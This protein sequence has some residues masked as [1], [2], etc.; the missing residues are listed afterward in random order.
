MK[1]VVLSLCAAVLL[2]CSK[3]TSASDQNWPQWR[4]PEGQGHAIAKDFPV[5]WSETE[6]IAWKTE[7]PGRGWSSPV[8]WGG[9]MWLTT[10]I[11][12]PAK[13]EDIER[14]T[15]DNTG[16]QLLNVLEVVSLRALCLDIASGK[17]LM[18]IELLSEREPQWVH[19]LNSYASPSPVIEEG[20]LYAHFGSFGSACLDTESGKV[21]WTN[22][23]LRIAHENG[24]GSTPVVWNDL[25]IFHC[26]GSDQ[27]FVIA[28]DKHTGKQAWKTVRSGEM[29]ENGQMKKAY[30]TPLILEMN[31][32]P[33][34]ISTGADWV[35]GY[36]PK[37]GRELWKLSYGQL[38]FSMSIRPIAGNGMFFF[39]TCFSKPEVFAMKYEGVS[40]PEIVWH[41]SKNGP[42]MASPVLVGDL[43]FYVSEGGIFSCVEAKNG[44]AFYRERLRGKFSASPMYAD[45]KIYVSSRE[46]VTFVV[47]AA[48]EFEVLAENKLDGQI[49]AS[50]AAQDGALFLRTD[51]A[52]YRIGARP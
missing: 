37:D 28:L 30:G 17:L 43:L 8:I 46:G 40:T 33:T 4:G 35:Y 32:Q 12:T 6:G 25:L 27:Q 44:R 15:K 16:D 5:K 38:G 23:D 36:D 10:A 29:H 31:G 3:N 19:Q 22:K 34:A 21:L 49:M 11:E 2:G 51:K 48:K 45:G 39:S 14:R 18:N 13:P 52:M 20:R 26:D 41:D 24:P 50:A 7:T 1:C 47:K 42:N 9:K